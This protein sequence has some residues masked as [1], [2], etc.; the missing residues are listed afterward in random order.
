MKRFQL[1]LLLLILPLICHAGG[2]G[3]YEMNAEA[4]GMAHA[5]ICRVND[6]SAVWYNPAALIRIEKNDLY[7]SGTLISAQGDFDPTIQPGI[8]DQKDRTFFPINAYYGR[9]LSDNWAFGIGAYTPFGLATE[10]PQGSLPALVSQKAS[11]RTFFITPSVAYKISPNLSIGAGMDIAYADVELL[12]DIQLTAPLPPV[13]IANSIDNANG[14][15]V[16]FNLGLLLDTNKNWSFAVTYKHKIDINFEGNTTFE[17]VPASLAPLF[18]DGPV[19]TELPLPAQLMLGA[20]AT[21]GKWSFEGDLIFAYWDAFQNL[22]VNFTNTTPVVRNQVTPRN[23]DNSW[24]IRLGT[25]YEWTEHHSFRGGYF[26][27]ETPVPDR[28]VDPILPDGSRNS[29][30][31]GYGYRAIHWKFDISYMHIFFD[32]RTSPLDNFIN[33]PGNFAAAGNYTNSANLLALGFGYKF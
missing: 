19:Q 12:R 4:N 5:F 18:P 28:S 27:D 26:Y 29:I 30:S 7:V 22:S 24:A 10:W 8:I 6:A 20:A 16:G 21:Y 17:N 13:V 3:I 31:F 14:T 15:D 11:L 2:Y 33:P 23:W 9:K 1:T 25:E 32:G